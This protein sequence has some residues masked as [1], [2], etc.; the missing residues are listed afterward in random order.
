MEIEAGEHALEFIA[1]HG[2]KLYIW[3]DE[4]DFGHAS[5]TPPDREIEWVELSEDGF[6]LYQD[7][8]IGSPDWWKLE[9]HHLPRAHVTA[10]WDGGRLGEIDL[11][12]DAQPG[13]V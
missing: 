1:E 3:I 4:A 2:G 13:D 10:I 9:F 5:P 12:P 6:T 8:A 7:A 11:A